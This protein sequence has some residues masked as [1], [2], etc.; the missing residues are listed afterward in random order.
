MRHWCG[1]KIE[2]AVEPNLKIGNGLQP[3]SESDGAGVSGIH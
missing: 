3:Q 1:A 2:K